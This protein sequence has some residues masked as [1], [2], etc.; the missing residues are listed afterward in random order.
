L[1]AEAMNPRV[2]IVFIEFFR[3]FSFISL[4]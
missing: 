1:A 2:I 4:W 3:L